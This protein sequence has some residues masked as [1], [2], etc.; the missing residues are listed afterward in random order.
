MSAE[1]AKSAFEAIKLSMTGSPQTSKRAT[2]VIATVEGDIHDIGKNIVKLLLENYGFSV[3]D[4]GKDVKPEEILHCATKNNARFVALSAL[5]TTT[6]GAM[7]DTVEL[8]KK[9]LPNV[10]VIVGGA[11]L[12]EEYAGKIGADKYARDAMEAVRYA[13]QNS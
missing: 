5:M 2:A 3:I 8:V 7:K 6:L 4:L 13:E 10:K 9:N 1:A 12:N 11:V